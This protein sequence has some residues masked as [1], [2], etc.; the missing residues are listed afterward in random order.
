MPEAFCPQHGPY[1]A[2]ALSCPYCARSSSRPRPPS[3]LDDDL[4]T[5]PGGGARKPRGT[6]DDE[7]P[8][9][10]RTRGTWR[11]GQE[12]EDTTEIPSRYKPD[13][14]IEV[15]VVDR[16]QKGLLGWL[17]VK[18]GGRYGHIYKIKPQAIIGRD[19]RRAT[20]VLD[21]ERISTIHARFIIKD[22]QFMLVDLGSSN[23][24]FVNGEA[25]TG[26][27]VVKEN[28]EIKMGNLVFVLKTLG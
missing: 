17:V 24:T 28:D 16:P 2:S 23:G 14:D 21:D 4:P 5:D 6:S 10:V 18:S 1:D 19:A 15:T 13:D 11:G 3:P 25:I 9:E 12:E 22:D 20:M 27:T 7:I 8:T 26:A